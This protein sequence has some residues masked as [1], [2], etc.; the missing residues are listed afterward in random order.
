[1]KV[2]A[3][4][5]P[6]RS[7]ETIILNAHDCHPGQANDDIAGVVVGVEVMRRLRE[8]DN[9]FSYRLVIA[10]EHLGTVFYVA[11]LP[12]EDRAR[13]KYAAFLEM[14][15]TR[16]QRL[17]LQESFTGDTEIDRAAWHVLSRTPGAE[18]FPFRKHVG[19]DETVWEAPGVEVPCVSISRHPYPEYHSSD[20]TDAI[21]DEAQ[22]EGAADAV[23]RV[24]EVLEGNCTMRRRFDGLVALGNP[25]YDLYIGN[26]DPSLAD[27][28]SA[29]QV[30]WNYLMD[31]LPR[32]FDGRMTVLDVAERHGLPFDD[33][34]AYVREF[35]RKGLVDLDPA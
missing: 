5:L 4:H 29:Q 27:S 19:N 26:L 12:A 11:D 3:Y 15:G 28:V 23:L 13:L 25:R 34:L 6:G 7:D 8:R 30:E 24:L 20:D 10:P 18:R 22:L 32:Y 17:G 14:L 16:G 35:E 9:R 1:M 21:I 33:V 31:C 2:C